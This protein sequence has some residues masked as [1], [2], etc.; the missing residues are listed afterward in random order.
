MTQATPKDYWISSSALYIE[1]NALGNPDY[2]QASCVSGAQILVYVRNIIT[3]DA[4]HNYR[5]WSLQASPTIFNTHTAKYVYAAIPRDMESTGSAYLVFPSE[6]LDIYGKNAKEEQ[7]GTEDYYYIY[8]QGIISSSGDNGTTNR[9]WTQRIS[10]GYLSSD[11]A[12]D[13]ST[14]ES[15]W[16]RYSSVDQIT[17]FLKDLTMKAGTKF[18]ELAAKTFTIVSGGSITFEG[19]GTLERLADDTTDVQSES[20]IVTPKYVD[21][22][23]LSRTHDDTAK[24]HITFEKGV[25]V[26][27]DVCITDG[28][29][30][31]NGDM[32][33]SGVGQFDDDVN[34]DGNLSVLGN[35]NIANDTTTKNLTVTGQA[36]FFELVIDKIKAAG[37]TVLFSA[38]NSFNIEKAVT[39]DDGATVRLYWLAE[40]GTSGSMNTWEVGDQAV[41]MDFNRATVG[42]TYEASN[43][44]WWALVTATSGNTPENLTE[45]DGTT[46]RYHWIDISTTDKAEGCTVVCEQGDAVAQWGSRSSDKKRQAAIMIAAYKSP[47][48]GVEAPCFVEYTGINSFTLTD[49]NRKNKIAYDG[50]VLKGNFTAVSTASGERDIAEWLDS[51]QETASAH[52]DIWYGEGAP[53]MENPP[54]SSWTS[55]GQKGDHVGDLYFDRTD[56]A[57]SSGGHCYRF[58]A[59]TADDVTTYAWEDYTDHDTLKAL[60]KAQNIADDG[61]ITAGAEKMQLLITRDAMKHEFGTFHEPTS[62][63]TTSYTLAYNLLKKVYDDFMAATDDIVSDANIN[64]DTNLSDIGLTASE[65]VKYYYNYHTA[66]RYAETVRNDNIEASISTLDGKVA[67]AVTKDGLKTA[68]I[69]VTDGRVVIDA[70]KTTVTGDLTVQGAITDSTSYVWTDGTL[71]SPNDVGELEQSDDNLLVSAGNTLFVPVDMTAI[72]SVQIQTTD[73]SEITDGQPTA[74]TPG[75]VA[76]PMYDAVDLGCGVTMPAYRRSGTRVLVRNAFSLAFT[77]W[78]KSADGWTDSSLD[79]NFRQKIAQSA[80]YICTDPRLLSLSNYTG[81]TPVIT[82]DGR[83]VDGQ[84]ATAEWFKGCMYLNGRRGRWLVLHPGQ[85]VELTSVITMWKTGTNDPV[86]YLAWYVS[87][88]GGGMDW[89]KKNISIQPDGDSYTEYNGT[90]VSDITGGE[91][92]GVGDASKYA[93]A[94][95]G[96]KQLSDDYA[97]GVPTQTLQ[98]MLGAGIK[99]YI[100]IG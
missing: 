35:A 21:D 38:A 61:V 52:F 95:F 17:T 37:G 34:I 51:L 47:D 12:I 26:T 83:D 30:D 31:V 76:L 70:A 46:H 78:A 58:T 65:F 49:A 5:R 6:E 74:M 81:A 86:P 19:Q 66:L 39:S 8:L 27:G 50:T 98:V 92:M 4:G 14:N 89:L 7:I 68:G 64:V 28:N 67:L 25:D 79:T 11:E 80:V 36:H 3:Y 24:G 40:S 43:K 60:T 62:E 72:K 77:Q 42:T 44:Y 84:F 16:Y 99:P 100:T 18:R 48:A 90:F 55:D 82:A 85:E 59:T 33:V 20:E 9:D 53:T 73:P 88:G 41:S 96:S 97:T 1:L 45:D 69:D 75:L 94:L 63:S 93:D 23:A 71:W 2:I 15:E 13:A 87:G 29:L 56:T 10:T 54:A 91:S 32:E 22:R 57:S